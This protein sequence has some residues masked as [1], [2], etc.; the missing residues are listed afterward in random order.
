MPGIEEPVVQAVANLRLRLQPTNRVERFDMCLHEVAQHA[1]RHAQVLLAWWIDTKHIP[2]RCIDV[3]LVNGNPE[4]AQVAQALNSS[5]HVAREVTD[6]LLARE[7][8]TVGKPEWFRK[9]VQ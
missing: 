8:I 5:R 6:V 1:P 4:I 7:T 2:H 3:W 9:V